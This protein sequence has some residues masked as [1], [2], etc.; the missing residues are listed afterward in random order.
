MAGSRL[1]LQTGDFVV[2]KED[3]THKGKVVIARAWDTDVTVRWDDGKEE[4]VDRTLLRAT[5]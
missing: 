3:P 1:D 2:D 4:I 5:S